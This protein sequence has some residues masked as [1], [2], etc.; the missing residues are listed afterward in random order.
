[1]IKPQLK[2]RIYE[3]HL[4]G[5]KSYAK[6]DR[7][8]FIE[9]A[10]TACN[11]L[12]KETGLS[13]NE[14]DTVWADIGQDKPPSIARV[15][16]E[17]NK[18]TFTARDTTIWSDDA[19]FRI[20]S[21]EELDEVQVCE[22]LD[23]VHEVYD[24]K[25]PSVTIGNMRES[26]KAYSHGI[27]A[28]HREEVFKGIFVALEKAVNFDNEDDK[29]KFEGKVRGLTGDQSLQISDFSCVN[30]RLKHSSSKEQLSEQPDDTGLYHIVRRWRPITAKILLL[31]LREAVDKS[32]HVRS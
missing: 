6:I 24:A 8:H 9:R 25:Y 21:H 28:S 15:E 13:V 32:K 22:V 1:M 27:V 23:M 11:L 17:S 5:L 14:I 30:N 2:M 7:Y 26:L 3:P 4:L 20:I 18:M 19:Q 10:L 31:R 12:L 16:N 29:A